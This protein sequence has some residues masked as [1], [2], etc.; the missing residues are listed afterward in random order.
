VSL[1]PEPGPRRSLH[2][3]RISC[4]AFERVD[5]LLEIEGLLVDT[6]PTAIRLLDQREIPAGEVIHQMRVR[7]TVDRQRL[8]VDAQVFSE[9]HPYV[10]CPDI[11]STYRQLV[12]M[13]I[14]RGFTREANRLFRGT[15]G[16]SH[17]SVLIPPVVSTVYQTLWADSDF[18]DAAA[19]HCEERTSPMG[20]CHAFRSDGQ[21]VTTFLVS[22]S[23]ESHP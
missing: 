6:K 23:K 16:C 2:L 21:V 19:E 13:R 11:E 10:E 7:L 15:K 1:A 18:A 17:I 22:P 3:R 9:I 5:G 14:D 12:G 20:G 8:I 4:E